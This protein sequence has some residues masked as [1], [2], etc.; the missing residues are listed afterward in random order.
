MAQP[1]FELG[2][3]WLL[4][5]VLGIGTF[6]LRLSFIQLHAWIDEF[7]PAIERALVFVPAAILAALIFPELFSL[8]GTVVGM[9][10]NARVLAGGLAAI[11][12]WRTG[13][14]IATIVVGM[15][16]LWTVQ[17]AIG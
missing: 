8:E 10:S 3:I 1:D 16:V 5:A 7:P 12:A 4:I 15:G 14:M 11:T 13:S 2:F 9:F 6:G 17:L